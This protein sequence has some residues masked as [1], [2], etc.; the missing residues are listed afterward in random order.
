ME[1]LHGHAEGHF[2]RQRSA[3]VVVG[4][5]A[6]KGGV[7]GGGR[8]RGARLNDRSIMMYWTSEIREWISDG[9]GIRESH[10]NGIRER[11]K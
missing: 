8:G 2:V 10:A 4:P 11:K 7:G 3:F 9:N 5:A 1:R 6:E